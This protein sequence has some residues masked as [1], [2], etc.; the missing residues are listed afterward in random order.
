MTSERKTKH[1]KE[2][3][4]CTSL[5]VVQP[6]T[7]KQVGT[8]AK[9]HPAVASGIVSEESPVSCRTFFFPNNCPRSLCES[10]SSQFPFRFTILHATEHQIKKEHTFISKL[11]KTPQYS[12]MNSRVPFLKERVSTIPSDNCLGVLLDCLVDHFLLT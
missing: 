5:R 2:I 10:N 8:G 11:Q 9:I 3:S 4:F 6:L 7:K 1:G 12:L